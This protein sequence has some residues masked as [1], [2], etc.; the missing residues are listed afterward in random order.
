MWSF[1]F[2]INNIFKAGISSLQQ[3]RYRLNYG[4]SPQPRF[5][6]YVSEIVL[7]QMC[8]TLI[9]QQSY[10]QFCKLHEVPDL[11]LRKAPYMLS[12]KA[13]AAEY[14]GRRQLTWL[15][16]GVSSSWCYPRNQLVRLT[17]HFH[18]LCKISY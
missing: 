13:N 3:L 11:S 7:G 12:L 15:I 9:S 14:L 4:A 16:S 1:M 5:R 10:N 8:Q 6:W 18:S 17:H 2:V